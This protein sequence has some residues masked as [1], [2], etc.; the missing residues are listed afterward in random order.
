MSQVAP[1]FTRRCTD[2]RHLTQRR[3]CLV[4][5]LAGLIPA[6]LGFGLAWPGPVHASTCPAFT[7]RTRQ[8]DDGGPISAAWAPAI[9]SPLISPVGRLLQPQQEEP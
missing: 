4:P 7:L 1:D 9:Q 8:I 5:D 6:G 2:C 3:T